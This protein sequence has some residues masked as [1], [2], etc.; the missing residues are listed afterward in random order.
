LTST[1]QPEAASGDALAVCLALYAL[2]KTGK[3]DVVVALVKVPATKT[4]RLQKKG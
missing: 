1:L 4:N 2:N 3:E